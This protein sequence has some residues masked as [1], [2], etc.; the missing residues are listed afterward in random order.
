MKALLIAIV[1]AGF[2][3]FW[4][5]L[6]FR[7]DMAERSETRPKIVAANYIMFR[8]AVFGHVFSLDTVAPGTIAPDDPALHLPQ[9]WTALRDWR[10]L[11]QMEEDGL[12]YCYVYGPARPEDI[13]AAQKLLNH[14]R[15]LGWNDAGVFSPG[16]RPLPAAIPS[17]DI[18]SVVRID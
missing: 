1:L 11:L 7:A 2:L 3:A 9:G 10:A 14:S 16:G 6:T 13:V 4:S 8:N 5:F 12:M 15:T 17:G 18:V